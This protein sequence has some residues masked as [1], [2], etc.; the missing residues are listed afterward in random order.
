[1]NRLLINMK[2]KVDSINDAIG[3]LAQLRNGE[4]I[5]LNGLHKMTFAV[6]KDTKPEDFEEAFQKLYNEREM[7]KDKIY[8]MNKNT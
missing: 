2:N 7:L 5:H 8:N 1:M 6:K 4:T 3:M